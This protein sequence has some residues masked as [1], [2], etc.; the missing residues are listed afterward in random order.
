M[1]TFINTSDDLIYLNQ[2]LLQCSHVAIDT[3]FR[4]TTKDNMKLS[5]IQLND[6]NEIYL[7][8]CLL[9]K[10]PDKTFS[11]LSSN[12]V[13]KIFHSCKE[14]LEA[15]YSWSNNEILNIYD[16]QTAHALLGGSFSIS[17]KDLV[18]DKLGL[19][20]SK[21]ETRTNWLKRP[22]TE[23]QLNYA[24]SDVY[25]LIDLY[26]LQIEEFS[27][28]KKLEW[29]DEELNGSH[30]FSRETEFSRDRLFIISKKDEKEI[31]Y[32]LDTIVK[33]ISR[34]ENINHTLF[35][36]K[37]NQKAL[38]N[39]TLL[40]GVDKSLDSITKWRKILIKKPYSDLLKNFEVF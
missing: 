10:D 37:Q 5:L 23:A 6:S 19:Y 21:E 27:E 25:Y 39:D 18:K 24:A 8:D 36:S 11:F 14:D 17:Y 33:K 4:R 9:I 30:L 15:L 26:G 31:L 3:E 29:L 16:T 35:L 7:V 2:E 28:A 32:E 40:L 34:K 12:Q 22:L 13:K 20:V 38:L 1:F